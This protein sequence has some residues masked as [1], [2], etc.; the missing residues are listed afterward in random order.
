[1]VSLKGDESFGEEDERVADA[2]KD[3]TNHFIQIDHC[4]EVSGLRDDEDYSDQKCFSHL[5]TLFDLDKPSSFAA[6]L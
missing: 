1:M 3:I 4:E 5:P 2:V 6:Q